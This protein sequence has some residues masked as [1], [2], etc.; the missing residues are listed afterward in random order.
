MADLTLAPALTALIDALAKRAANDYLTQ[1]AQTDQH[2]IDQ[3]TDRGGLSRID[4]A[5]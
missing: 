5:A 4:E 3:R 1:K 2:V